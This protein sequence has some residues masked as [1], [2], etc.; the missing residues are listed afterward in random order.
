MTAT[1]IPIIRED[2]KTRVVDEFDNSLIESATNIGIHIAIVIASMKCNT[3][4][5][6][7]LKI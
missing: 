4:H 3:V 5:V 2:N 7:E 6:E 1:N